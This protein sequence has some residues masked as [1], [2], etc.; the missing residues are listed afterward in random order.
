MVDLTKIYA[1]ID[2]G[3][4]KTAVAECFEELSVETTN[5]EKIADHEARLKV[6]EAK[7]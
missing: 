3:S 1:A 4:L 6:V 2:I 5:S 7:P